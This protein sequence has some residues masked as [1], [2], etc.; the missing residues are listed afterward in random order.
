MGVFEEQIRQNMALF[1]RAMKMFTPFAFRARGD[2]PAS[3]AQAGSG[4][5][6]G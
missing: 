3:A 4:V 5:C 1:D 2:R 6:Q